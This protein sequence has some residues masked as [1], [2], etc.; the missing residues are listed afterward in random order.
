[1]DILR[2]R[3]TQRRGRKS[4]IGR[5][6]R[7]ERGR[8]ER[9]EEGRRDRKEGRRKRRG[10]EGEE[11]GKGGSYN[12][13]MTDDITRHLRDEFTVCVN[14]RPYPLSQSK[15]MIQILFVCRNVSDCFYYCC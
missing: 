7:E 9:E 11:Q 10:R 1:M 3:E 8:G 15:Y 12:E 14:R 13:T 6:E 2:G 4:G 5:R